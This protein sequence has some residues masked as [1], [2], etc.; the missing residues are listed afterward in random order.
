MQSAI[1]VFA[2][3]RAVD[4]DMG[5]IGSILFASFDLCYLCPAI[6]KN[7]NL[8]DARSC[9]TLRSY[10]YLGEYLLRHPTLYHNITYPLLL[11]LFYPFSKQRKQ[12]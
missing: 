6:K 1:I 5:F 4:N 9:S 2:L 8:Y 10:L 7:S 11:P 3:F 12:R